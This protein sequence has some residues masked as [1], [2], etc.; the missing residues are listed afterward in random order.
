MSPFRAK[1]HFASYVQRLPSPMTATV[2][3]GVV[4]RSAIAR[5]A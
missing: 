4:T 5:A 3:P 2:A 1:V